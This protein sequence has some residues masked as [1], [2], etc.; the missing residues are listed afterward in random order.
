MKLVLEDL[1]VLSRNCLYV[2]IIATHAD[3]ELSPAEREEMIL[4]LKSVQTF[5]DIK[6]PLTSSAH[7]CGENAEAESE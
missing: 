1:L 3:H 7:V 2:T 5:A 6:E 4:A